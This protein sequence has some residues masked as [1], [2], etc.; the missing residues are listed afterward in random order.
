M[1]SSQS[2]AFGA[3]L[4]KVVQGRT[5]WIDTDVLAVEGGGG[6][7]GDGG[8]RIP[9]ASGGESSG[10]V[11]ESDVAQLR[12]KVSALEAFVNSVSSAGSAGGPAPSSFR[13]ASAS[14]YGGG[15]GGGVPDGGGESSAV[16]GGASGSAVLE[17][18]MHSSRMRQ[19]PPPPCD[20]WLCRMRG[21]ARCRRWRRRSA[22]WRGYA[23]RSWSACP[24][25]SWRRPWRR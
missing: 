18:R 17:V 21:C 23:R 9:M 13:A 6:G 11:D 20:W 5:R 10:G 24:A 25:A 15:G 3:A 4:V 7:G 1:L 12:K 19:P 8:M 22:T 14:L 2:E 16:S